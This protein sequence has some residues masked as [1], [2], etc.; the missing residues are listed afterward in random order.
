MLYNYL[1]GAVENLDS[2]I[3][4]TQL[5]IEDIKQAR[6]EAIFSRNEEKQPFLESFEAKKN[7]AQQ[8]IILLKSKNPSSD[9]S[10]I[11]DNQTS[12]LLADLKNKLS[13]LKI[14]N[15]HYARIVLSVKE[16]YSSMIDQMFPQDF[17]DYSQKGINKPPR[18]K[19]AF[20]SEEA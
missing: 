9:I 2:L 16:F 14:I 18:A 3:N 20:L 6:H 1:K 15:A 11:L 13:E 17:Q 12:L 5:D 10:E 7:L 19:S 8:E 4:L